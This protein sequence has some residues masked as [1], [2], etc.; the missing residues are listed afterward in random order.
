MTSARAEMNIL[1][2]RGIAKL[3]QEDGDAHQ[4]AERAGSYPGEALQEDQ[5]HGSSFRLHIDDH[6][7]GRR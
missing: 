1:L 5:G 4:L 2:L 6:L 3:N 7:W